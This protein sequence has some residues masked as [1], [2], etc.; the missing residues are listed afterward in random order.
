MSRIQVPSV[1]ATAGPSADDYAQIKRALCPEV[2]SS[3][4]RRIVQAENDPAKR[5]VREWLANI[6]DERLSDFGLLASDVAALR[7]A[8]CV[9]NR[10]H[11]DKGVR[12]RHLNTS[13]MQPMR[14]TIVFAVIA[15]L[16]G[17][18][19]AYAGRWWD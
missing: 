8:N 11:N 6:D 19:V 7:K 14:L 9:Q 5:R 16:T 2:R 13:L 1:E 4:V 17:I 18:L 10:L 12:V 3:L 15:A